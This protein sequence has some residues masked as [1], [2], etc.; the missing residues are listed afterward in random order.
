MRQP[1][2]SGRR[3]RAA[4]GGLDR[5]GRRS[6]QRHAYTQRLALPGESGG[7]QR[8]GWDSN[9]RSRLTRDS[10]FQERCS[11]DDL[12]YAFEHM[13]RLAAAR[14][15]DVDDLGPRALL[16]GNATVDQSHRCVGGQTEP[17]GVG[18]V[19]LDEGLKLLVRWLFA[20]GHW[21]RRE[22][23]DAIVTRRGPIQ[24]G[25]GDEHTASHSVAS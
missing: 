23:S 16:D 2:A 8:R 6:G 7:L 1:C 15:D 18:E 10:G 5:N 4:S 11:G 24:P 21:P 14:A 17:L 25:V 20:G 12:A 13:G 3:P 19:V 22:D 9:P